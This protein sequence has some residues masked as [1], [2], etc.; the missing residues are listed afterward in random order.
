MVKAA[1]LRLQ[2]QSHQLQAAP[3]LQLQSHQ[4]QAAPLMPAVQ[5]LTTTVVV[6]A[7]AVAAGQMAGRSTARKEGS[8]CSNSS[9]SNNSCRATSCDVTHAEYARECRIDTW[10]TRALDSVSLYLHTHARFV[11][12]VLVVYV[13]PSLSCMLFTPS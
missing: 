12:G 9:N 3:R 1:A 13:T 7:R 2:L 10:T 4:L 11:L 8:S 5:G 6:V